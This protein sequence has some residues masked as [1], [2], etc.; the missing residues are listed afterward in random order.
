M[1]EATGSPSRNVSDSQLIIPANASDT[2]LCCEQCK[3]DGKAGKRNGRKLDMIQC[4]VCA[5]W[6]H[7]ECVDIKKDT[8]VGVWPC[9]ACRQIPTKISDIAAALGSMDQL[10]ASVRAMSEQLVASERARQDD[11]VMIV[12]LRSEIIILKEKVASLTWRTFRQPNQPSSLLIGSSLV[13]DVDCD[14]LVDTEVVC[15][16]GGKLAGI[17]KRINEMSSGYDSI[18]VVAGGNDCDTSPPTPAPTVIDAFAS[19]I[20]AA[21]AKASTV[22]VSSVCPRLKTADITNKIDA[23]NAGLVTLC[24]DKKVIFADSTPSF[25][26]GDGSVNDGYLHRD[27]IHLTHAAVNRLAKSLR[28]KKRNDA[29]GVCSGERKPQYQHPHPPT[30]L[31]H[32][33]DA[34]WTTV[35]RR[36]RPAVSARRVSGSTRVSCHFCGEEGHSKDNCRH[37]RPIECHACHRPG[38][39]SKLCP[40]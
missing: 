13:R 25:T 22:T 4:S 40:H 10:V 14:L 35:R 26:L 6:F 12:A 36:G 29:S 39:K 20:D 18:T 16:P 9:L 31:N 5:V 7:T 2:R 37:G 38:H 19:V 28:L 34:E 32:G 17:E 21:K 11:R 24:A 3:F 30:A 27:G 23:V 33:G 15:L 1:D 8:P